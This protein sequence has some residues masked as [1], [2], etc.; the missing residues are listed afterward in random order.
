MLYLNV[1]RFFLSCAA[2]LLT[3]LGGLKNNALAVTVGQ[4]LAVAILVSFA[5]TGMC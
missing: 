2:F 1:F 5:V 4:L 3:S